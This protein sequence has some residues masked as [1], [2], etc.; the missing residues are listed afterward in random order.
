MNPLLW[1]CKGLAA[2]TDWVVDVADAGLRFVGILN[3][4]DCD[5]QEDPLFEDD[6]AE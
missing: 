2:V 5:W 1:F 4:D 6:R 3:D